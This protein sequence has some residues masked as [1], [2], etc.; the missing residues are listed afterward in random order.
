MRFSHPLAL[1]ALLSLP[2]LIYWGPSLHGATRLR[3]IFSVG[4]RLIIVTSLILALSGL[5]TVQR[6]NRLAVMFL[7]DGSDSISANAREEA[8]DFIQSSLERM[9]PDDQAGLIL[10]GKQ[11]VVDRPLSNSHRLGVLQ[12]IPGRGQTDIESAINLALALMPPDA[13]RRIV[14]ISDGIQTRGDAEIGA[15]LATASGVQIVTKSLANELQQPE[16][17]IEAVSAPAHLHAGENFD[18]QVSLNASQPTGSRIRVFANGQLTYQGNLQVQ[19][20]QQTYS[21][22]LRASQALTNSGRFISYQVQI[23]PQVDSFY[24]NNESAAYSQIEGPPR[25]LVIAPPAGEPLPYRDSNGPAIRPNEAGQL[26]KVIEDAGYPVRLARP[27][28]L[29]DNLS[30]LANYAA[31]LLVD[32]PA[33]EL[34]ERQMSAVQSFVRDLGGGL[35]VIGGPTSYGVGGYFRTPL[36]ETLPVEMQMKDQLRRPNLTMVFVID[37]SGSMGETSGGVSKLA[38]AKEAAIRSIELLNP[39]DRVGVLAFDDSATWVVPISDLDQPEGMINRIG[40]LRAG[41]GTDILAGLQAM[42]QVLPDDPASVKHV[43]LLTDGGANPAGIPELVSRMNQDDGITLSTVGVGS[44]AA[45]YLANLAELGGGR[46]HFAADPGSIPRIFTEETSLASRSYIIERT[47]TPIRIGSSPILAGLGADLPALN[48]YVG[49]T[50]RAVAQTILVSDLKDPVLASWQYGLGRAIAFTSDASGRWASEWINW[51]GFPDF[52]V[53]TIQYLLPE[54]SH[55][56]LTL[57]VE[58]GRDQNNIIV[59][60]QDSHGEYLNGY[61]LQANIALPNGDIDRIDLI[62]TAPGQYTGSFS[63]SMQGAYLI[64]VT[65]QPA[66]EQERTNPSNVPSGLQSVAETTGWVQPY[67]SEYRQLDQDGSQL[68]TQLSDLTGGWTATD[69]NLAR[70]FAHDL[71]AGEQA[72]PVWPWLLTLAVCL[73]PV[74]I[75]VRRLALTPAEIRQSLTTLA[76]RFSKRWAG[77]EIPQ[78]APK[79]PSLNAFM[80][81]KQRLDRQSESPDQQLAREPGPAL[82]QN[83]DRRSREQ[84]IPSLGSAETAPAARPKDA[85]EDSSNEET[86]TAASLLAAK[87]KRKQRK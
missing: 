39:T 76:R 77:S 66:N 36:E 28:G 53:Q 44:D 7:L 65:G 71:P 2:I 21:L 84:D 64:G 75:A 11:A 45:P 57:K 47:F 14:L 49:T 60:A 5:E 4:I 27:S 58:Q 70:I 51:Q 87:R 24:Q 26:V 86:T 31:I 32:V 33:R 34:T 18:L 40:T 16:V 61:N 3:G 56:A 68:L 62:Q 85:P 37:H 79:T 72:T 30:E 82:D 59:D 42:A 29:P 54:V 63:P 81:A 67:S 10:F 8:E 13:A 35:L 69:Q 38:L 74:D 55:S 46:Y 78:E 17:L 19:R 80:R 20:G 73:L 6:S 9:G 1:L 83:Q 23:D 52:W 15:R 48:G 25:L 41:G 43:I 22:P 12:S 50:A